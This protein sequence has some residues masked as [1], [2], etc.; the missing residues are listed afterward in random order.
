MK[1]KTLAVWMTLTLGPIGVQR[2]YLRGRWDAVAALTTATSLIGTYGI[3]RARSFGL[4]DHWSWVLIPWLGLTVAACCLCAI[5]YGLMPVE[6]WNQQFNH[7]APADAPTGR[8]N[9]ITVLGLGLALMVGSTALM[10]SLA[11]GIQRYFEY[12]AETSNNTAS[13]ALIKTVSN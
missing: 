9:W 8:S 13:M 7:S 4:D 10:A 1:N 11:F 12:E 5:L 3:Y 2:Y 6:R